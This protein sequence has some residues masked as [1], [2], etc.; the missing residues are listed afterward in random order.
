MLGERSY[1]FH[2]RVTS[3]VLC[4]TL[5]QLGSWVLPFFAGSGK[6]FVFSFYCLTHAIGATPDFCCFLA[7]WPYFWND[8]RWAE[9]VKRCYVQVSLRT[10][11]QW[12]FSF[13]TLADRCNGISFRY[14]LVVMLIVHS[15]ACSQCEHCRLCIFRFWIAVQEFAL[16]PL[17][18]FAD[19]CRLV[20]L[21]FLS[22]K[23]INRCLTFRPG[24]SRDRG[25]R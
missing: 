20:L 6:A 8:K 22:L 12:T 11:V 7:E 17:G 13:T 23:T 21:M 5:V 25:H 3:P 19:E 16:L 10:A 18:K 9:S 14:H 24:T 1:L 15:P 2:F 4:G